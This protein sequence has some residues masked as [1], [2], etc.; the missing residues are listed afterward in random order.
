LL[1]LEIA[2]LV[3]RRRAFSLG[4]SRS[5]ILGRTLLNTLLEL[6][7]DW[8]EIDVFYIDQQIVAFHDQTLE[9]TTNGS[10]YLLDKT[11]SYLRSLDAGEGEQIPT[12]EEVLD[13]VA[14]RAGINIEIKGPNAAPAVVKAIRDRVK[15]GSDIDRFLVS[16]FDH[17]ELARVKEL[18]RA[19]RIGVLLDG[20]YPTYPAIAG[21]VSAYSVH[22]NIDYINY[23]FVRDAHDRGLRV[24]AYTANSPEAIRAMVSTGVDGIFT[25]YPDRVVSIVKSGRTAT[26]RRR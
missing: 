19:I 5:E 15:S 3:H 26:D 20:Y 23:K 10:G 21:A 12:L 13:T 16:S 7:A 8:I 14:M 25:D 17:R 9:R 6:G 22:Q 24:F 4:P 2:L 1:L 11:F 18:D